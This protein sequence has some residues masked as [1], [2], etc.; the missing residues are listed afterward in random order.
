MFLRHVQATVVK[1]KVDEKKKQK[2]P[3]QQQKKV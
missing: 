2:K 3:R 1:V